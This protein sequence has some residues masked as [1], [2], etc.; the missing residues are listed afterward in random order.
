MCQPQ[1]LTCVTIKA[2]ARLRRSRQWKDQSENQ[3]S[4]ANTAPTMADQTNNTPKKKNSRRKRRPT[5][6][7]QQRLRSNSCDASTASTQPLSSDESASS[8]VKKTT[9]KTT[10]TPR[11]K[12]SKKSKSSRPKIVNILATELTDEEK[13]KYVALDAEMVGIG[14]GGFQSRLARVSVVNWDGETIYDTH[15]QVVEKVTDYR[16]FVSGITEEDLLSDNAVTFDEAQ[17]KV[18]ELL[19]D[20]ILVGHGLRN[21]FKVL[22]ISHPWYATR[23]TAKYEP[24]MKTLD[25]PIFSDPSHPNGTT[26]VAK[27]L[28]VLA[29]DKLGMMIQEE[30]KPHSPVEDAVA[31]LELY[32]KHRGKWEKAVEWK[33]ERTMAITQRA[34]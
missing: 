7:E 29:K 12:R 18:L 2:N 13:A 16:T 6:K 1:P 22:G 11:R 23:D 30:G 25:A 5:K 26:L 10:S 20:K 31:A 27:K 4:N 3:Q 14:P 24:F 9:K 32:K 21:D 17:T 28:K 15:V 34:Q 33:M 19:E 8:P